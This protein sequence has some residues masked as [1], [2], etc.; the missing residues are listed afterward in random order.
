MGY[1]FFCIFVTT[2]QGFEKIEQIL[3]TILGTPKNGTDSPQQQ[4]N[5]P[6]C[7]RENG[8]VPDGKYNLEINVQLGVYN[9]WKCSDTHGTK[10]DL[11]SLIKKYGGYNLYRQ[12]K[13][14]LNT[15]IK[16]KLYNLEDFSILK[17]TEEKKRP[18]II[19]PKTYRKI[20]LS[21]YCKIP[22][23]EYLEK[24]KI[25]QFIIDK[26][27]IGYTEWEENEK[28]WSYRII[29][30]SYDKEGRL[31]FY[32]GRD[33]TNNDKR[34]K[35]RNCEGIKKTDIIFQ[36]S[37]VDWDAPIYLC[38]GAIDCLYFPNTIALL[39]KSLEQDYYLY[40]EIKDKANSDVI[41]CLD[42]DTNDIETKNIYKLLNEGRLKNKIKYIR[43]G[44]PQ[45]PY[46]DFGEIYEN[47]KKHGM[48]KT[49]K[50]AKQFEEF[51][52]IY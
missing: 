30:P 49:I 27:N 16:L 11:S 8:G 5:C 50:T 51:D 2:M 22:V 28:S 12:Y 40:K 1:P 31:N 24:R 42:G 43:L 3:E 45:I 46:K 25:D 23:R 44:T 35:Y 48:I 4:Y 33:Y 37:L 29:I 6:C 17:K 47:E 41:V 19:L 14:E 34:Q 26:F 52:L 20:D 21:K 9:C 38:E 13:E 18:S 7:A 10:G 36:E 32:V 15:L 39:G